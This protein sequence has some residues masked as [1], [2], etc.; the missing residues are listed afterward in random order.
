MNC[1]ILLVTTNELILRRVRTILLQELRESVVL[2]TVGDP[3]VALDR[4]AYS[5]I[6]ILLTD[7]DMP[8]ASVIDLLKNARSGNR[9][10]RTIVLAGATDYDRLRASISGGAIDILIKPIDARS[11]AER[12]QGTAE[13]L[14]RWK[15]L[16]PPHRQSVEYA[17]CS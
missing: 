10:T 9:L 2:E 1:R 17:S 11:L 8:T 14:K 5:D 13:W 12:I 4:L 6:D 15:A 3:V 7:L 16:K